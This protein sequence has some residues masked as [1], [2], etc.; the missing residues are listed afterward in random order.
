MYT[1]GKVYPALT[2][3]H[4]KKIYEEVETK[5]Y[6]MFSKP[7]L[8]ENVVTLHCCIEEP[9]THQVVDLR[10]VLGMVAKMKEKTFPLR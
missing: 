5:L 7:A 4:T 2:Q 9:L 6:T 3:H 10:A 8:D 1:I